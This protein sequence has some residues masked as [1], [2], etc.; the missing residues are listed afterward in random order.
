M[1]GRPAF[2]T[3]PLAPESLPQVALVQLH[4]LGPPTDSDDEALVNHVA[5]D[6]VLQEL[7][8]CVVLVGHHQYRRLLCRGFI[9][10]LLKKRLS[11]Y[12]R[13]MV[14]CKGHNL[15]A[16]IISVGQWKSDNSD[17][18]SSLARAQKSGL[19]PPLATT[20]VGQSSSVTR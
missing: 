15:S 20:P 16:P 17:N 1:S 7:V 6:Q 18:F 11:K 9:I 13:G 5:V 10:V 19:V 3:L 14:G 4:L 8:Q 2:V 12:T